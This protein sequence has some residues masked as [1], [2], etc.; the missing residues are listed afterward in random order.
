[1]VSK[2]TSSEKCIAVYCSSISANTVHADAKYNTSSSV[3]TSTRLLC[4]VALVS[5]SYPRSSYSLA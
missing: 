4:F 1:M 5:P 2:S 3:K